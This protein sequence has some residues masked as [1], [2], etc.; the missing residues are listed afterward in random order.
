MAVETIA[1]RIANKPVLISLA[2]KNPLCNALQGAF[3]P[4]DFLTHKN[5]T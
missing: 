1:T 3:I 5:F 2:I 4:K